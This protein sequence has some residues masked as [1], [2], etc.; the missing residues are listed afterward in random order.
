MPTDRWQQWSHKNLAFTLN[1]LGKRQAIAL[2]SLFSSHL[3]DWYPTVQSIAIFAALVL[4]GQ[5]STLWS[6]EASRTEPRAVRTPERMLQEAASKYLGKQRPLKIQYRCSLHSFGHLSR[7]WAT[8][9]SEQLGEFTMGKALAQLHKTDQRGERTAES[10]ISYSANSL[11]EVDSNGQ[12]IQSTQDDHSAFLRDSCRY[13]PTLLLQETLDALANPS[14]TTPHTDVEVQVKQDA[15]VASGKHRDCLYEIH[16]AQPAERLEK[17]TWRLHHEMW[18]DQAIEL[19]YSDEETSHGLVYPT[20][21]VEQT[22]GVTTCETKIL[23]CEEADA[24]ALALIPEGTVLHSKEAQPEVCS[25]EKFS[26]HI[27]FITLSHTESR[28]VLVEFSDF[29]MLIDAPMS[30]HNGRLLM[31][32]ILKLDLNKP[33]KYF[34]FGHHHPHYLGGVRTL[35]AEGATVVTTEKIASYVRQLVDQAH[36]IQP[37]DLQNQPRELVLQTFEGSTE[38]S[39]GT[40]SVKI[41][42]IGAESQH[43]Y[44]YLLFYFPAEKLLFQDDGIWLRAGQP[45]NARTKGV[46]D[47]VQRLELDVIDAIQSWPI[48]MPGIESK[49]K[50]EQLREFAELPEE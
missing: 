40:Y 21:V 2:D 16:F 48:G 3:S 19:S 10:K 7:P 31:D 30:S 46:Y 18:G 37:D 17:I 45:M 26:D 33:V 39:D 8:T 15:L 44:D 35:V 25:V 36:S 49:L 20:S 9:P 29:L 24:A 1:R 43:T 32:A 42:D 34:A 28:C 23:S 6:Q 22:F 41:Y 12:A 4:V 38:I 11:Y 5:A 27:S 50:M 47:A 13:S 14:S